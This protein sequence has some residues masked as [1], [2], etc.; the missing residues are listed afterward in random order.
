[1]GGGGLTEGVVIAIQQKRTWNSNSFLPIRQSAH[2]VYECDDVVFN[3]VY[4][5]S[6]CHLFYMSVL[7]KNPLS[8]VPF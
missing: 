8:F 1:M 3:S 6:T 7:E 4:P 2:R 5:N